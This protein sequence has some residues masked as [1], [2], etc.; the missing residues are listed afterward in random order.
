MSDVPKLNV[1]LVMHE[2]QFKRKIAAYLTTEGFQVHEHESEEEVAS[3]FESGMTIHVAVV[4]VQVEEKKGLRCV[5]FIKH[6][7]NKTEV[8]MLNNPDQIGSSILG[9]R[10]GAFDD[11]MVPFEL[12]KLKEKILAADHWSRE[13]QRIVAPHE[14]HPSVS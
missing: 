8:V 5:E 7:Y 9:M 4:D 6:N 1:L 11:I 2:E 10:L 14:H 3:I 12:K 13:R